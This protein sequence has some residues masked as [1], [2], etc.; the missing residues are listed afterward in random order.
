MSDI[1]WTQEIQMLLQM[2]WSILSDTAELSEGKIN[3]L[4]DAFM[5]TIPAVLK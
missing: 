5:N 2:F 1:T 4:V 3:E